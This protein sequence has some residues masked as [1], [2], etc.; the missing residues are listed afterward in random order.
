M[1]PELPKATALPEKAQSELEYS[2]SDITGVKVLLEGAPGTGKTHSIHTL[3]DAGITPYVIFTEN[4]MGVLSPFA[5]SR[6]NC[7][8][9]WHYVKAADSSWETMRG[10]AKMV[11]TM[12]NDMLQKAPGIE[13]Q[14][15]TQWFDLLTALAAPKC[16]RCGKEFPPVD[17]W[18]TDMAI[19]VD[20][21]SGLNVIA[22]A[23]TVGG[24]PI[25]TQPDW[26]VCMSMED[27][28]IMKLANLDCHFI[29]TSHLDRTFDQVQGTVSMTPSALGNKLGPTIPRWFDD[30]LLTHR[31]GAEYLW[32]SSRSNVDLKS[33]HLPISDK[34]QP[35]FHDLIKSWKAKGGT[36]SAKD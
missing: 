35:S 8:I 32:S 34:L 30:V 14:K 27:S 19:V 7:K 33:R 24:K 28:L 13:K 2:D 22:R 18:G 23:L 10:I 12:S 36:I 15:H 16:S 5:G 6:D 17:S 21:L 20:S 11:N 25:L 29:L 3:V 9:H 1:A 31:V 26:G 4:S